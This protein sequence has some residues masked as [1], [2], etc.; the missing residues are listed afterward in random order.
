MVIKELA[1]KFYEADEFTP[2][3]ITGNSGS[4]FEKTK[5]TPAGILFITEIG[6]YKPNIS[7]ANDQLLLNILRRKAIIRVIDSAGLSHEIGSDTA[8][9]SIEYEKVNE[10]K[11][12]SKHGYNLKISLQSSN[13]AKLQVL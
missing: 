6:A 10:G 7:L 13:P 8:K 12:G 9:A 5:Q 4:Y 11:P 3:S 2:L 1:Y